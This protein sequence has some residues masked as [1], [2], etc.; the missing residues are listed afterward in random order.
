MCQIQSSHGHVLGIS[1]S[2]T[3]LPE[4]GPTHPRPM[5]T[6]QGPVSPQR[7]VAALTD[8]S[9]GASHRGG[10]GPRP[11]HLLGRATRAAALD[12]V[13]QFSRGLGPSWRS[14]E[15]ARRLGPGGNATRCAIACEEPRMKSRCDHLR[16]SQSLVTPQSR[17]GRR[18]SQGGVRCRDRM[19]VE[20]A[21]VRYL[22]SV[23]EY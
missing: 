4:A 10:P 1:W 7:D 3:T 8:N 2:P 12:W 14:A 23:H 20:T 9:T 13:L 16:W 22:V 19:G 17:K 11:S 18:G 15:G 21:P 6:W 5:A